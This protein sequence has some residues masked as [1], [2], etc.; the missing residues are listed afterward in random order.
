MDYVTKNKDKEQLWFMDYK[1]I[2]IFMILFGLLD[3]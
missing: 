3:K 2:I 1:Y